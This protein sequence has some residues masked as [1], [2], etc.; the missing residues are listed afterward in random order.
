MSRIIIA[1]CD[2]PSRNLD[3]RLF[4]FFLKSRVKISKRERTTFLRK[5]YIY[6]EDRKVLFTFVPY[7]V[8]GTYFMAL[9][10]ATYLDTGPQREIVLREYDT[11]SLVCASSSSIAVIDFLP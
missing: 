8:N 4:I 10:L 1:S 3:E 7:F 11:Y 2:V 5:Y 9:L 6:W